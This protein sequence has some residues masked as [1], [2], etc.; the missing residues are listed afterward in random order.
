MRCKAWLTSLIPPPR[1][2]FAARGFVFLVW[3]F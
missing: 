3:F 2:V 1:V